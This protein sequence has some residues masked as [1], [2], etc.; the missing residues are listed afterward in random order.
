MDLRNA[1][2]GAMAVAAISLVL[3]MGWTVCLNRGFTVALVPL[4]IAF[5]SLVVFLGIA[6]RQTGVPSQRAISSDVQANH[7]HRNT[8]IFWSVI[9]ATILL[10]VWAL[11]RM[12]A[13]LLRLP[14]I[15]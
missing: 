5:V 15:P 3:E 11:A 8:A 9:A 2:I 1:G 13:Q 7:G 10:L 12:S 14:A 6:L 4:A